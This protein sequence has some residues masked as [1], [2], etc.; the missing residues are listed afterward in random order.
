[1]R[2]FRSLVAVLVAC[3]CIPLF[4]IT[5]SVT[6]QICGDC[7][8]GNPPCY[9]AG[10]CTGK[11]VGVPFKIGNDWYWCTALDRVCPIGIKCCGLSG[12][13]LSKIE[14][15]PGLPIP[16]GEPTGVVEIFEVAESASLVDLDLLLEL[17]HPWIGDLTVTLTHNGVT[18]RILERPGYP[19]L[20]EGCDAQMMCQFP[21]Y[22]TD[23]GEMPIQCGSPDCLT[24]FPGGVVADLI[25]EPMEAL[26]AFA[27]QDIMGT[28]ELSI[29]DS[30]PG[31][32]GQ[33]C[34][35]TLLL[36]TEEVIRSESCSWGLVKGRYR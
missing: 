31:S 22:L 15:T 35:A 11:A 9:S 34:A 8:N 18:V 24:C 6:A 13:T 2:S 23:G 26:A 16:D 32:A 19:M 14:Y 12:G 21:V 30:R 33:L 10:F 27:G 3:F 17:D 4:I 1:M 7:P 25:Y 28:W 29:A 36:A 20:P 5:T